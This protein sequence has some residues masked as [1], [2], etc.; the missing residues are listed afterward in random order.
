MLLDGNRWKG[1]PI[2][3]SRATKGPPK[4]KSMKKRNRLHHIQEEGKTEAIVGIITKG[5][6]MN[7]HRKI[8][9]QL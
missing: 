4:Y 9:F 6:G 5:M 7:N 2:G 1:D 8:I 3:F